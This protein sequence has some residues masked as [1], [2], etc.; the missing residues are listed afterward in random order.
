MTGMAFSL[1]PL[2]LSDQFQFQQV[3]ENTS[4]ANRSRLA[5]LAFGPLFIWK[6]SCTYEWAVIDGWICV[7]ATYTDGVFMPIPPLG[8]LEHAD[9]Q[10]MI[11][12]FHSV[13]KNVF[14][15][16]DERNQGRKVTRIEHIPEELMPWFAM[17]PYHLKASDG[18]YVYETAS[19]A[20]LRGDRYKS[21]RAACNRLIR[22]CSP[23]Y[24]PFEGEDRDPCLELLNQWVQQKYTTYHRQE[25][26][27]QQYLGTYF[28]EDAA[29][30][31]RVAMTFH[32]ELGLVG[33]VISVGE[34]LV[35]YTFGIPRHHDMFCV[36]LEI[37]D[38]TIPGLAQYLFR[39]YAREMR[40]FRYINTLDDS[41]LVSLARSK[42]AYH[43]C[44]LV[45]SYTASR[46]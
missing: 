9:Q 40:A 13:I 27:D 42:Q 16:M 39:E 21:Q 38:R 25:N 32:Q 8:P 26:S 7:F 19:L 18:E 44:S 45:K 23:Q 15:L 10:D 37:A 11:P 3:L 5:S 28:L 35:A 22:T 20:A 33:R 41:G 6:E 14:N 29:A 24:R 4:W 31:H 46:A 12:S 2:K 30:A 43:P 17:T 1:T 34:K 36:L